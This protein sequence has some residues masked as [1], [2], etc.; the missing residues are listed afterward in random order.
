MRSTFSIFWRGASILT[1][2][3]LCASVFAAPPSTEWREEIANGEPE[4]FRRIAREINALQDAQA[5][6]DGAPV[7]RGFHSKAHA[8]LRARF[9]VADD[10]PAP[11]RQ[12]VF[13]QPAEYAA[14]VR[15]SNGKP[16]RNA[17]RAGDV[18]G[19]A[20]KLLRVPGTPLS[21]SSNSLDLLAITFAAQPARDINQFMSLVRA[22]SGSPAML[23]IR[24][25][26]DLG[27]KE[28]TR[29]IAWSA[30]H[31]GQRV[32]S[33]ATHEFFSAVPIRYGPYAAKFKFQPRNAPEAAVDVSDPNYLRHDLERR[34][35]AGPLEYDLLVQLYTDPTN[36]PI[37]DASVEWSPSHAPFV[38]VGTLTIDKRDLAGSAASVEEAEGNALLFNPWQ[39]PAE[40]RPLGSLMRA[41]RIVYPAS[42]EHRGG[43]VSRP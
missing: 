9:R 27:V 38:R 23:P 16:G 22:A 25:T 6:A 11:L 35:A 36:T 31:I 41:R 42:F 39:A 26:Q 40:H 30:T 8:V 29:I 32:K 14:W 21:P 7:D 5:A 15:Y 20:V 37:E 12:G 4:H 18:R 19:M 33:V 24:L 17:D 10:I 1:S 34:L 2:L 3:F 43:V 13:Q 28:A